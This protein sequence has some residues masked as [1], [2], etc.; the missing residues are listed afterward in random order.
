MQHLVSHFYQIYQIYI[1]DH[2]L[3]S[4]TTYVV[5]IDLLSSFM[6]KKFY[7]NNAIK[8]YFCISTDEI[9]QY[10]LLLIVERMLILCK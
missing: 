1:E 9:V 3:D 4:Q 10:M 5:D 6:K 2:C 8:L 7:A